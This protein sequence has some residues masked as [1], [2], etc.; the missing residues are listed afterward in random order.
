M[1]HLT[2]LGVLEELEIHGVAIGEAGSDLR[3]HV[4]EHADGVATTDRVP[5]LLE[6]GRE[7]LGIQPLN[8]VHTSVVKSL[9]CKSFHN[10]D[11]LNGCFVYL[12]GLI[13]LSLSGIIM[14]VVEPVTPVTKV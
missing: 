7:P 8:N 3:H 6:E 14:G 13:N 1:T 12:D 5:E 10:S 4:E 9:E 11:C 2:G